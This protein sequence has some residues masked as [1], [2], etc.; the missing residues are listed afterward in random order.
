MKTIEPIPVTPQPTSKKDATPEASKVTAD[1]TTKSLAEGEQ[2]GKE[3]K[4]MYY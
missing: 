1:P 2:D 4:V 3:A